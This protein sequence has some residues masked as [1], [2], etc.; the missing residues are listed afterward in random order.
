MR[1]I[2]KGKKLYTK[3]LIPGKSVYGEKLVK[4]DGEEF[5]EWD[6]FRSK[7]AAAILKGLKTIPINEN[8]SILYLGAAQGT[9]VS[10]ISDVAVNG[11]IYCVEIASKPFEKLLFLCEERKN[12]IPILED[13][14]HP[15]RYANIVDSVDFLYQDVS[16]KNQ[17]EIFIKNVKQF[18]KRGGY[19]LIMIKARSIDVAEDSKIIFKRELEKIRASGVEIL[20]KVDLR[21]FDKDHI[22][23]LIRLL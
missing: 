5:R 15:E 1:I 17:A 2:R 22:A 7:L 13:A 19:G 3:N 21:P 23:V 9:T 14:N 8:S 18:L 12:L 10:H 11:V 20:E 6:P 16:Q 4:I